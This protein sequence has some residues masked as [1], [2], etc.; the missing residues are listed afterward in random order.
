MGKIKIIELTKE[1]RQ[2]LEN[3]YRNG[4]THAFRQRCQM[5]LLKSEQRTSLEI[6]SLVGSCEMTV[7][8]WLKRYQAEGF[9]GLQMRPG[10][11]RK[12][13][14]QAEDFERV[15]AQVKASRQRISVA[16]T[17]LEA[18]LAKGFSLSTLKRFLK[19]TVVATNELENG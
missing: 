11:G 17:V 8:N 13:I 1:K 16:H 19:K 3:G 7:N 10:R 18:S 15:K 2:D 12:S 4:Q 14:L 6:S 9:N 5:I